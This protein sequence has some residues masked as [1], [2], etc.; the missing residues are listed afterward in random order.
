MVEELWTEAK[1]EFN[2]I[3]DRDRILVMAIFAIAYAI[4]QLAKVNES[5]Q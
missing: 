3:G 2:F 5:R 4:L 1:K